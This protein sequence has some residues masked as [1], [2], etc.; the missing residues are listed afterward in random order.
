MLQ[1][2]S[3]GGR[4][5]GTHPAPASLSPPGRPVLSPPCSR[6]GR[7]PVFRCHSPGSWSWR[8]G[9]PPFLRATCLRPEPLEELPGS[10]LQGA[11]LPV[12][13]PHP[14]SRPLLG[15]QP[16]GHPSQGSQPPPTRSLLPQGPQGCPLSQGHSPRITSFP[17]GQGL[18]HDHTKATP[19]ESPRP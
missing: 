9:P 10:R 6:P 12:V 14:G 3:P 8:P 4:N 16:K 13:S 18:P 17:Q 5:H 2:R 15:P 7:G 19:S 1:P 11:V